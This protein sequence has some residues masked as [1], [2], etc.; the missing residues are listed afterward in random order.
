MYIH[1]INFSVCSMQHN[2][3]TQALGIFNYTFK[4]V[5]LKV[6]NWRRG[7]GGPLSSMGHRSHAAN[8]TINFALLKVQLKMPGA[9]VPKHIQHLHFLQ[10]FSI[11]CQLAAGRLLHHMC[12][13]ALM[14]FFVSISMKPDRD[15][16]ITRFFTQVI[17]HTLTLYGIYRA[18]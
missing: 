3:M 18:V 7:N 16:L 17:G 1:S 11:L 6:Q 15:K 2:C 4:S 8:P 13:I 12:L 14:F 10:D 5:V 9:L